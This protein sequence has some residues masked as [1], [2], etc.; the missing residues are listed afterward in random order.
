MTEKQKIQ[1]YEK[2]SQ[3]NLVWDDFLFESLTPDRDSEIITRINFGK[4]NYYFQYIFNELTVELE[5]GG[6]LVEYTPGDNSQPIKSLLNHHSFSD[7]LKDFDDWLN[8]LIEE[9]EA[10]KFLESLNGIQI[11]IKNVFNSQISNDELFSEIEVKSITGILNEFRQQINSVISN[12]E[13]IKNINQ[14]LDYLIERTKYPK[15]DWLNIFVST[16]IQFS[17]QGAIV[18]VSNWD[19]VIKLKDLFYNVLSVLKL[20]IVG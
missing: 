6:W 16:I 13:Q 19:L 10:K 4:T 1:F 11:G 8:N 15:I 18:V 12:D 2:V 3:K 17:I 20:A 7:V 5:V 14:K 9:I